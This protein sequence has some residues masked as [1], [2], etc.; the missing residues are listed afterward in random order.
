MSKPEPSSPTMLGSE[1]DICLDS[2]GG[3]GKGDDALNVFGVRI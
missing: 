2:S 1:R 3:V